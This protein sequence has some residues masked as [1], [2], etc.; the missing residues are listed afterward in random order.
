MV[1]QRRADEA[2]LEL[3]FCNTYHLLLQPGPE[4]I[5]EAGGLHRYMQR[6]R[7]IITDSGGFQVFSLAH[8]SVFDE[9]NM[10]SRKNASPNLLLAVSEDGPVFRSYRDG[11]MI[12]LTPERSVQTQKKL[13]ADIII[14]LDE[15]PPYHI[16][17]EALKQSV[18]LSHR[19]EARSLRE[20]LRDLRQQAM[21]AV[22]HGGIDRE[23]RQKSVEY[24]TAL[25]FDGI[26]IGGSLGK[27]RSELL[28]LLEFLTPLLPKKWPTHLLGIADEESIRRAVPFGI[29]SFDSCYPTRAGR[30]G[31]LLT[32]S[33][34]RVQIKSR[35]WERVFEPV[36]TT[37]DGFVSKNHTLAYLHHLWRAHEPLAAALLTLHNIQYMCDVMREIRERILADDL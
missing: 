15:L 37:C 34:G 14:P 32:R 23:L 16:D 22:I 17:R 19:W 12:E 20:H 24:L 28:S 4:V 31:T 27:D 5:A 1:D 25:P 33:H 8:G 35:K 26:A 29:D 36:D 21:F 7:P 6:T 13:G 3:L 11:R 30:H 2:G 9:L 10:K 18:L